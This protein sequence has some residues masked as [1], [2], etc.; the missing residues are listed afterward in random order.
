MLQRNL[1]IEDEIDFCG[2][3]QIYVDNLA[4]QAF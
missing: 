2:L 1:C 4:L 3:R